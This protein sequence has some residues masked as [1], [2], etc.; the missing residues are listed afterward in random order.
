MPK[1]SFLISSRKTTRIKIEDAV[2]NS[3]G[4]VSVKPLGKKPLPAGLVQFNRENGPP[5]KGMT[6]AAGK[7]LMKR[8]QELMRLNSKDADGKYNPQQDIIAR[9]FI[10]AMETGSFNHLKEYIDREE[11][12]IPQRIAGADGKN[13]K[14]Y[15]GVATEGEEAP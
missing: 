3:D 1:K 2:R 10:R 5:S 12:K 9:A 8:I 14:L 7:T 6:K 13:I 15:V 4:T 11:G